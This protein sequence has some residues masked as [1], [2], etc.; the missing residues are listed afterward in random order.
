[1][2][3]EAERATRLCVEGLEYFSAG[4][5]QSSRLLFEEALEIRQRLPDNV[6]VAKSLNLLANVCC[7][8]G[9]DSEA[10]RLYLQAIDIYKLAGNSGGMRCSI[11]NLIGLYTRRGDSEAVQLYS[12]ILDDTQANINVV[13]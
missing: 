8:E 3:T 1:L 2:E 11:S 13:E 12:E 10:E 9:N 6:P 4:D 7:E 5:H